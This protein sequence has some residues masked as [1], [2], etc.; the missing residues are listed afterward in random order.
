[1]KKQAI[2]YCAAFAALAVALPASAQITGSTGLYGGIDASATV[3]APSST[4]NAGAD[5]NTGMSASANT[6]SASRNKAA[7][8]NTTSA[9]ATNTNAA[10]ANANAAYNTLNGAMA[11]VGSSN[12]NT[13]VI[14]RQDVTATSTAYISPTNVTTEGDFSTYAR[15][16]MMADENVTKIASNDNQVS[17]WYREPAKFLG[18][19]P[20]TATVQA[21]VDASGNVTVNYP[22]WYGIFVRDDASTQF[23]SDLSN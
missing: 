19:V 10:S 14:T 20:V 7:A 18:L 15:A 2:A 9:S 3:G 1:M 22:W 21:T 8:N 5:V 11:G 12:A 6:S 13:F 4:I 17:V 23:Q 16:L